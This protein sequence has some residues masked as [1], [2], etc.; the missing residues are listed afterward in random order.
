MAKDLLPRL[1]VPGLDSGELRMVLD[2]QFGTPSIYKK[3]LTYPGST[4]EYALKLVHTGD[5]LK[6]L[7]PG[8]SFKESD[9]GRL[10]EAVQ[11]DLVD[12]PGQTIARSVALSAPRPVI[13][14]FRAKS[15]K[16]QLIPAP[17]SAPRP[18]ALHGQHPVIL[19]FPVTR[20]ADPQI[21][22]VRR[23]RRDHEILLVL[24][25]LLRG[26]LNTTINPR[27]RNFWVYTN[28]FD[29]PSIPNRWVWASE[30]YAFI[31]FEFF[32]DEFSRVDPPYVAE[33]PHAEY[34]KKQF[35]GPGPLDQMSVPDSLSDLFD[36]F[37]RLSL[38]NRRKY[39]RAAQWIRIARGSWDFQISL[40][41]T[42][43]VS[44]IETLAPTPTRKCQTCGT[45]VGVGAGVRKFLENYAPTSDDKMRKVVY[46]YRS[47]ISHGE[48]LMHIDESPWDRA[49]LHAGWLN[50]VDAE[51]ALHEMA[52]EMMVNWLIENG[53]VPLATEATVD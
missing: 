41:F 19:E 7:E 15:G 12:S 53:R 27:P 2:S 22:M 35:V 43:L 13:G 48:Q 11:R 44:A 9:L 28:N 23:H 25:A 50:E 16:F 46:T 52:Q 17:E 37:D 3:G 38:E 30:Q 51:E 18:P 1:G 34:Y 31:P 29:D 26:S 21:T 39:L 49:R 45:M 32:Q 40:W 10:R 14:S 6:R 20:S 24:S 8:P 36:G 42:A 5:F 4:L 33:L 47:K